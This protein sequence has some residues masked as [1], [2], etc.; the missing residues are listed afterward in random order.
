[1]NNKLEYFK[2][3]N[4]PLRT[5]FV[6]DRELAQIVAEHF[7]LH[8]DSRERLAIVDAND[9]AD[10][11]GNNDHVAQVSLDDGGLRASLDTALGLV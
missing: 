8:F 10:H 7:G 11:V 6:G 5:R 2:S 9:A 3:A 1:M 4:R